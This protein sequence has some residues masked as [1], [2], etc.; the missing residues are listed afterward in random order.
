[1]MCSNCPSKGFQDIS[2]SQ[3]IKN[4]YNKLSPF[5]WLKDIPEPDE[6]SNFVEV[7]FKNNRKEIYINKD[8]INV[9]RG[10][11]VA[12][13]S[14][15]GYDVGMI[16]LT[17]KL[18]ELQLK[19]KEKQSLPVKIVYRRASKEEVERLIK[20]RLREKPVMVKARQLAVSLGLEMK[21][22]DVE[23]Q[24]DGTKATFY[25][26]ADGRVDF[27]ELIKTYAAEF[28]VKIEMKQLGARQES[29]LIGGIGS[30]GRELC[31]SSWRKKLDTVST[32]AARVQELPQNAEKLTGQCGKLKCCLMYEL[33]QYIE[34]HEDFPDI[35]LELETDNGIALPQKRDLLNKIIWYS[36]GNE[37]SEQIPVAL[38]RVKEILQLNKKGIKAKFLNEKGDNKLDIN[39]SGKQYGFVKLISEEKNNK[40]E[41]NKRNKKKFESKF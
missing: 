28:E 34:A 5:D 29:A 26:I 36:I 18:V 6:K 8:Q 17:G 24:G 30:C 7:S 23:F 21:I 22:S 1:M 38:D 9:K 35:L 19:S 14:G 41:K 33:D 2:P 11:Y 10:N 39:P 3:L 4:T 12:V 25:Y 31:C 37:S 15:T 20:A 16:S 40:R 13:Q 27:R 32:K